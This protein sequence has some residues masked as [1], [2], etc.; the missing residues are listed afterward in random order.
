MNQENRTPESQMQESD[1]REPRKTRFGQKAAVA[2]K[3]NPDLN[4]APVVVAAGLGH[5]AQKILNIADEN[6]V[7]VYRDDSAAALLVMLNSGEKIP[8]ELYSVIAAIYAEV[9]MTA[10]EHTNSNSSDLAT[11]T[12]KDIAKTAKSVQADAQ[13][14]NKSAKP[15]SNGAVNEKSLQDKIEQAERIAAKSRAKADFEEVQ[16]EH[17]EN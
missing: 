9:V 16:F 5:L 14:S 2:L 3:Y 4:Y 10:G 8:P 17:L 6:G 13:K 15:K 12:K 1:V 7:P 11:K